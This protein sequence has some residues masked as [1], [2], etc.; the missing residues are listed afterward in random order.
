MYVCVCVCVHNM[1]LFSLPCIKIVT[2]IRENK[3]LRSKVPI[4]A[5]LAESRPN[6]ESVPSIESF[7]LRPFP[8]GK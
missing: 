3:L 7:T 4:S 1:L 6:Y 8:A 5:A 2:I